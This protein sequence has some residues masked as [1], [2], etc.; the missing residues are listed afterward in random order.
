MS[1][2]R[3]VNVYT[4]HSIKFANQ[5]YLTFIHYN[6]CHYCDPEDTTSHNTVKY[7]NNIFLFVKNV[8]MFG[9][10]QQWPIPFLKSSFSI[11][12][13]CVS[14][15]SAG[16]WL[17]V[18]KILRLPSAVKYVHYIHVSYALHIS[19]WIQLCTIQ[20]HNLLIPSKRSPSV[21]FSLHV[22]VESTFGNVISW[23]CSPITDVT[24]E[25][26]KSCYFYLI[27]NWASNKYWAINL[28]K[29]NKNNPTPLW[30]K[31]QMIMNNLC[32]MW[33]LVLK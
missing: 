14:L 27:W 28:T 8:E 13:F 16:K 31:S 12:S 3:F 1:L 29:P 19:P 11:L 24:C 25:W 17:P 9:L 18:T 23:T 33:D 7:I 20:I 22:S 6:F 2:Y 5:L 15:E 10:L 30:K 21:I 26:K 32:E 4:V